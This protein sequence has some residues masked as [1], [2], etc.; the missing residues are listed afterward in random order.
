MIQ[1]RGY[2]NKC[3][4]NWELIL[5]YIEQKYERIAVVEDDIFYQKSIS[6][7]SFDEIRLGIDANN[8]VYFSA[9][10]SFFTGTKLSGDF[11]K[12]FSCSQEERDKIMK[13]VGDFC[14][15]ILIFCENWNV[16]K[17]KIDTDSDR[18]KA[19]FDFKI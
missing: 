14:R 11:A 15:G 6:D 10:G 5:A 12:I 8:I 1:K 9:Y 16:I 18:Y 4:S 13:R 19:V 2:I 17:E 7:D 3:F